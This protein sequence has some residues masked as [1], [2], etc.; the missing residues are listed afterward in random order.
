METIIPKQTKDGSW[1][2][3]NN[4]FQESYHAHSGAA[5][6][7]FGKHVEP[8][9]LERRFQKQDTIHILDFCF[10]LGYNTA[11]AIDVFLNIGSNKHLT[12]NII[13]IENDPEILKLM[14][15]TKTPFQSDSILKNIIKNALANEKFSMEI[16]NKKIIANIIIDQAEST[17]KKLE[18][19]SFDIIFF[20][21]FSPKKC[22]ELWTQEIFSGCY[23]IM[24]INGILTTYSC[25][26][27]IRNNMQNSGFNIE[28]GPFIDIYHPGTLG[29]KQ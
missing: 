20:D 21:P 12:L 18:S 8:A 13:G 11:A 24:K 5:K 2:F 1:T 15:T 29:I 6:E 26:K 25:A 14:A 9:E 4:K 10:G 28:D 19:N 7:A 17:I 3:F 27:E 22:P 16:K 23:R